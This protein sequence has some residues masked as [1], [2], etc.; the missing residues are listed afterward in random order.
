MLFLTDTAR[1]GDKIGPGVVATIVKAVKDGGYDICDVSRAGLTT[2]RPAAEI[3]EEL[4]DHIRDHV[5]EYPIS[6]VV[7]LGGYDVIPAHQIDAIA[8]ETPDATKRVLRVE[9]PDGFIIWSDDP[10]VDVDNQGLPDLPISRVPDGHDAL[11]TLSVLQATPPERPVR[12]GIR[13]KF[14]PFVEPIFNT[15]P[16]TAPLFVSGPMDSSELTPNQLQA[17]LAYYMLHGRS[18]DARVFYG[19]KE[20]RVLVKALSLDLLPTEGIDVAV[21]GCCWGA[22][23]ASTTGADWLPGQRITGR[24]PDQSIAL[25]LLEAGARAVIGCTGAHYSP[26]QSNPDGASGRLH[27]KLWENLNSGKSPA[28]SLFDAKYDYADSLVKLT[29]PK[30]LAVAYKTLNQFTCL[31]LGC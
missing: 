1:L 21:L 14:R 9:D 8:P 10:Y 7:I 28:R 25:A 17:G 5:D 30:A 22:L 3:R 15:L 26:P 11:F 6:Q 16:G 13:N 19:E 24:N 23:S 12:H 29:D 27:R 18:D 4:R 31:G 20:P 2:P